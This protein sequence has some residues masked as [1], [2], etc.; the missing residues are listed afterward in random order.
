MRAIGSSVA[1]ILVITMLAGTVT[2]CA[3]QGAAGQASSSQ[4]TAA[5]GSYQVALT[6]AEKR[7]RANE[8]RFND[9]VTGGVLK[10]AM[11]GAGIGAAAALLTGRRGSSVLAGAALGAAAGGALGAYQGYT[12]AKLQQNKMDVAATYNSMADDLQRQNDRWSADLADSRSVHDTSL[13]ELSAMRARV[14]AG[15][16]QV[17]EE[18]AQTARA[19][20]NLRIMKGQLATMEKEYAQFQQALDSMPR[21]AATERAKLEQQLATTRANVSRLQGD[22][23]SLGNALTTSKA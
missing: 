14:K 3:T 17:G 21:D 12:K 23:A 16:A 6:D 8:Q 10:N 20:E 18:K 9:V 15:T 4:T 1:S 7:I 19:E 5:P 11:I 2:G 13:S 22:V